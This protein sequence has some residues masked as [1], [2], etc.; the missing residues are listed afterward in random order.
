MAK[1]KSNGAGKRG[2]R[3]RRGKGEDFTG[4]SEASVEMR[5]AELDLGAPIHIPADDFKSRLNTLLEFN[6]SLNSVKSAISNFFKSAKEVSDDMVD[7]L[8]L[9]AKLQ[10]KSKEKIVRELQLHGYVLDHTGSHVQLTLHDGLLG[11]AQ[12]A[13][14]KRGFG[15]GAGGNAL[16]LDGPFPKHSDLAE[17]FALGWRNG[18]NKIMNLPYGTTLATAVQR[19]EADKDESHPDPDA[20][21]GI[22]EAEPV[23]IG[24]PMAEPIPE[25]IQERMAADQVH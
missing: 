16:P 1:P 5:K 6:K 19:I 14:Y 18:Q 23:D 10:T 2:G 20:Q 4:A 11:S 12:D 25:A 24:D 3:A 8:K 21:N 9:A 15:V 13:A 7:A 22:E 17:L